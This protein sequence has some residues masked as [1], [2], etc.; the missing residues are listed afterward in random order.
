MPTYPKCHIKRTSSQRVPPPLLKTLSHLH[1]S[2]DESLSLPVAEVRFAVRVAAGSV[3]D[4][5]RITPD[6]GF[7]SL[8]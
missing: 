7:P 1:F 8:F 3:R 2:V 6:D 4:A 5:V